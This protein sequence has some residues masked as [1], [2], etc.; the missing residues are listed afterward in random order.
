MAITSSFAVK[1]VTGLAGRG[2]QLN[3]GAQS[4]TGDI[5]FFVHADCALHERVWEDIR[6]A[7]QNGSRWGCCSMSFNENT[8]FFRLV[9]LASHWRVKLAS[10]CYGDQGIFCTRNLFYQVDGFPEFPF[11]EDL[12]F[13]H[14]ARRLSKAVA[15]PGKITTSTRRFRQNGLWRTLLKMQTVKLLFSLGVSPDKLIG[16]YNT[17]REVNLCKPPS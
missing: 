9:A 17:K 14:R 12:A 4:A 5:F 7:V 16:F 2:R 15:L 11:L 6:R 10:S 13:S 1:C 8:L 3:A